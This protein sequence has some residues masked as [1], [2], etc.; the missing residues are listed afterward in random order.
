MRAGLRYEKSILRKLQV[1]YPGTKLSPWLVYKA[2]QKS[3]ICQP[4]ALV[5][6]PD[7]RLVVVEVKLTRMPQVRQ[8]LMKFYG[9]LVQLLYPKH[10]LCYLQIYKN[11]SRSAHKKPISLF[12]LET[13]KPGIYRECQFLS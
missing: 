1:L 10:E 2:P 9:P 7:G 6:F 12:E 4:D 5:I 3:G 8:K 11:A 13:L